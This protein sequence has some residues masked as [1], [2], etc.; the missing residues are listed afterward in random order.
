VADS[1]QVVVGHWLDV[2][3][4]D[5]VLHC[6]L[7]CAVLPG[8]HNCCVVLAG[9]DLQEKCL[10]RYYFDHLVLRLHEGQKNVVD[11][12]LTNLYYDHSRFAG[13][14]LLYYG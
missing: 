10:L 3:P 14:T 9:S 11:W 1:R 7:G 4:Q 5:D 8:L 13:G 6:H 12:A 2:G